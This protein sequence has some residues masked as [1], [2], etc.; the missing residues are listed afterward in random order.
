VTGRRF[1]LILARNE[2]PARASAA[3]LGR[4]TGELAVWVA[5]LR[6]WRLLVMAGPA[7][8]GDV[9]PV[10]GL[11]VVAASDVRSARALADSCSAAAGHR[12]TVLELDAPSAAGPVPPAGVRCPA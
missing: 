2:R 7:A 5:A 9:G 12:V 11:L 4:R 1:A 8:E 3:E 10:R 6:R